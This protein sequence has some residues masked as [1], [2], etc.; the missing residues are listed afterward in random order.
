MSMNDSNPCYPFD[1]HEPLDP[2]DVALFDFDRATFE[3]LVDRMRQLEGLEAFSR[4]ATAA[5]CKEGLYSLVRAAAI[6][7]MDEQK[8]WRWRTAPRS[9]TSAR[10]KNV[11]PWQLGAVRYAD[12]KVA[13]TLSTISG[14]SYCDGINDYLTKEGSSQ[15]RGMPSIDGSKLVFRL[16]DFVGHVSKLSLLQSLIAKGKTDIDWHEIFSDGFDE[17][18]ECVKKLIGPRNTP[19]ISPSGVGTHRPGIMPK[20]KPEGEEAKETT[21]HDLD[22]FAAAFSSNPELYEYSDNVSPI[23]HYLEPF[24][25]KTVPSGTLGDNPIFRDTNLWRDPGF[26]ERALLY[27]RKDVGRP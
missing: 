19:A 7:F 6:A 5:S 22:P 1:A 17:Y 24:D 9:M 21:I 12:L 25:F 13:K 14:Y 20:E 27:L 4:F 3:S 26:E 23:G 15:G 10:G 2:K 18:E 16:I 8:Y 11:T